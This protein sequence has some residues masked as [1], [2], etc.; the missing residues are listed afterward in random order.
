MQIKLWGVR[1]SIPSPLN[2]AAIEEKIFQAITHLPPDLDPQD[3][4]GVRAY[5]RQMP[6]LQ[7]GTAGGNTTCVEIQSQGETIIIDA[8]SGLREL[9]HKLMEGPC[10]QGKGRLNFIF[11]HTHW[12]HVQGFPFFKPAF[13]PGNKLTFYSLHDVEA[14]LADQQI[15]RYFPLPLAEMKSEMTFKKLELGQPFHI[16]KTKINT[17]ENAHPG[18]AYS[19]RLEDNNSV[20]VFASDSEYKQLDPASLQPHIEF[21]HGADALI[22]DAQYTLR[23]SWQ[24]ADWGHSSALIGVD[25]ARAARV[26][27]LILFHHDPTYSDEEL[28]EVL[29]TAVTYQNQESSLPTCEIIIGHEELTL[30]LSPSGVVDLH[31]SDSGDT[32]ILVPERIFG[33]ESVQKLVEQLAPIHGDEPEAA[34]YPK[35]SIID[36]S[37]VDTLTLAGLK[38]LV[39]LRQQQPESPIV[40]VAPS[41]SVKQLVQLGN[42]NDYFAIYPTIETAE[43]AIQAREAL[44]LPGHIVNNRY[45]IDYSIY[46]GQLI[47]ILKATCL[48]DN[49]AVVLK[50]FDPAL[51]QSTQERLIRQTQQL[52]DQ[53]HP[54]IATLYAWE[55]DGDHNFLVEEFM[56]NPTLGHLLVAG[57]PLSAAQ[58]STIIEGI[59]LALEFAHGRGVIH[60]GLMPVNIFIKD[61]QVQVSSF[62]LGRLEEGRKYLETPLFILSP[63]HLA[64]EQILGQP[65]DARTDLY[66]LGIII[67]RLV[68]GFWPFNSEG[69]AA[70]EQEI[71]EAQLHQA[72]RPPS[73]LN[74]EISTFLEHLIL[75]LLDKN[76]N[77]RYASARQVL[78]IWK[79][80]GANADL[81]SRPQFVPLVGR[82]RAFKDLLG[83][84]EMA[85]QGHGQINFI[86]G[87]PGIGKS[88][89]AQIVAYESGAS[90]VLNGRPLGN[91]FT[92]QLFSELLRSYFATVPPELFEDDNKD[93]FSVLSQL[94]PELGQI[95]PDLP[96]PWPL[97]PEQAQIRL[98]GSLTKFIQQATSNRPWLLILE[99]L[100]WADHSSLELLRY[101]GRHVSGM[102]L[103][104][105]GL[106]QDTELDRGHPLSELFRDL[107]NLQAY[108]HIAL[109]RLTQEGVAQL[110]GHIWPRPVSANV[111]Q[112]I[113]EQT[114]GNPLYVEEVAKGLLDSGQVLND[115][116][117]LVLPDEFILPES[118]QE[119]VRQR[120]SR[121]SS[122]TQRLLYQAAVLGRTF[123]FQHLQSMSNLK[124]RHV[125]ELLDAALDRQLLQEVP[126]EAALR[127][128]HIEIQRVLYN[129]LGQLRRQNL[130]RQAGETLEQQADPYQS[131]IA[132]ELAHHF[133]RA[134]ELEKAIDYGLQAARQSQQAYANEQALAGYNRVFELLAS[135]ELDHPAEVDT[136]KFL[137]HK[138]MGEVLM[139]FGRYDEALAHFESAWAIFATRNFS[140]LQSRNMADLCRHIADIY[141]RRNHYA[142]AFEWIDKGL[143][144]IDELEPGEELVRIRHLSGWTHMRE[145]DFQAAKTQFTH[146]LALSQSL[147]LRQAEASSLRHLGTAYWYEERF[148]AATERW[149]EALRVCQQIGDRFGTGKV[150]NNM[151]LVASEMGN[152]EAAKNY[153]EQASSILKETG[154]L[155]LE[156]Q[157]NNNLGDTL[158]CLGQF[159]AARE[160]LEAALTSCHQLGDRHIESMIL[161][162]LSVLF[163]QLGEYET[164]HTY[165]KQAISLARALENG[166]Q[167]AYGLLC[168]G[169]VLLDLDKIEAA[170]AAF[171]EAVQIRRDLN[172]P[173]MIIGALAG[174]AAT[175]L[176]FDKP[177]EAKP[178]EAF[179]YVEEILEYISSNP[180]T[181]NRDP[182]RIYLVCYQTLEAINHPQAK[183]FIYQAHK[184]LELQAS[185]IISRPLRASFYENVR[186][187]REIIVL[188]ERASQATLASN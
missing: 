6:R 150:L 153:L 170:E 131:R 116:A 144:F 185:R 159:E 51:R 141:Q 96:S 167:L 45:K 90:V 113:Y 138:Y 178:E 179:V 127:F 169:Y 55:K 92:Y 140:E 101:L 142:R 104:I 27:R 69:L 42:Y 38:A 102:S 151:G 187:N 1:G 23:E 19:Y 78:R 7:R 10:G 136:Q 176:A 37:H 130:H 105:M 123:Q 15:S 50:L 129:S 163:W 114:G 152:Y 115:T 171:E 73:E 128:S 182:L 146:A 12:D 173:T 174:L 82:E 59:L 4:E 143:S 65:L 99:D 148:D 11:T 83:C 25:L 177:E 158:I 77:N 166:R 71:K 94:V 60:G 47:T 154:I 28:Q 41:S 124:A 157:V 186:S 18:R 52:V 64:P 75:K 32:A 79:S 161:S 66:S 147:A 63:A 134:G 14:A 135:L 68:T 67:Y 126:G 76:P 188:V 57:Q 168:L 160:R 122:E 31:Y 58:T 95:F 80:L 56:S 43:A 172:Q 70:T 36:L 16:G 26:K 17:I 87:E 103:M 48:E 132:A 110:L 89:L 72:P 98:M 13:V 93:I 53:T 54:N 33:L 100:Q 86:S 49:R 164:A 34:P 74:H 61:E 118:V 35:H 183:E 30:D 9:G 5:I 133:D 175:K 24:R 88:S 139:V 109:E 107:T 44:N 46:R 137:T 2:S 117:E 145:G 181:G 165:S 40:L 84:W 62:G 108:H 85:K 29:E 20:F 21:F 162:N 22:F 121:L 106:Y 184:Q 125:L 156:F 149:Q 97:E 3:V 155:W 112:K 111:A 119:V 91:N 81:V 8:G 120:V 39:D 180:L